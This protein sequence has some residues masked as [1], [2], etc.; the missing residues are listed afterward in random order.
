MSEVSVVSTATAPSRSLWT[1]KY[2]SFC[3][4]HYLVLDA[5]VWMWDSRSS[6]G[7]GRIKSGNW[8]PGNL[9]R[10]LAND[11]VWWAVQVTVGVYL[12]WSVVLTVLKLTMGSLNLFNVKSEKKKR[13]KRGKKLKPNFYSVNIATNQATHFIEFRVPAM[14]SPLSLNM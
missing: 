8:Q 10:K 11:L 6:Q 2:S 1:E 3:D 13:K 14:N 5:V 12:G 7:L 9:E 4:H